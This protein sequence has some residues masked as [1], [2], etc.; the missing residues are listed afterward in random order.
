MEVEENRI[1]KELLSKEEQ[2]FENDIRN[3]ADRLAEIIDDH[4]IEFTSTG[5]QNRFRSG[6][7]FELTSG[8]SYIDS[9]NVN[10][11]DIAEDCKMLLYV[12]VKVN[13]NVR[14]KSNC[15]SIWKKTGSN[16]KIVFH[17]GTNCAE[18]GAQ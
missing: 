11:I 2:L 16:W 18:P 13:K 6:G 8:V 17:Q 7:Q 15:S 5:K 9:K 3:D 14:I 4:Y 1:M 10:L 12:A